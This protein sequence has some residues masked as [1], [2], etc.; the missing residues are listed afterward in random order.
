MSYRVV[1]PTAGVGSRLLDQT[2]YTNKSLINISNKPVI[3][4][5]IESF[6]KDVEFVIA[7]GHKGNLVKVDTT[8]NL[9][10]SIKTKKIIFKVQKINKIDIM[11]IFFVV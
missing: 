4:H 10:D 11:I 2:Q 7:L 3:S 9:L 5:I 8:K 6:P 1:I